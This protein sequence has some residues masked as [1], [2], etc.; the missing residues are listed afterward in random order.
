MDPASPDARLSNYRLE[1][2]L[3]Q[4]GM[5]AVYLARDLALDRPVAIKFISP[6]RA[7][8]PIARQ[9]L[10]REARAAASLDHPNICVIHEVIDEP[11]GRAGSV[12]QYVEGETLASKLRNGPLDVRLALSIAAEMASALAVAHKRGIIHR[13]IKPQNIV[14]T[15]DGHAKLLDF[16]LALQNLPVTGED[17]TTAAAL[18]TPGALAGTPAYMS[19]EQAQG[20]PLDGRSDL[21]SLGCVL[22]ECLTGRRPFQGSTPYETAHHVL[23]A[24]PPAPS[25]VRSELSA[26]H[27][28][29]CL[30]LLAKHRDDRFQS[31]DELLGAVRL[32]TSGSHWSRAVDSGSPASGAERPGLLRMAA[33]SRG[34]LAAL[35]VLVAVAFV[36]VAWAAWRARPVEGPPATET[37]VGVLPFVNATGDRSIDSLA[38]GLT[39]AIA[40]RLASIPSLRVLPLEETREA[41]QEQEDRAVLATR[42]TSARA[43]PVAIAKNLGAAFVIDGSVVFAGGEPEVLATLVEVDG[44]RHPAGQ[45]RGSGQVFELHR[46]VTQALVAVLAQQGVIPKG[47]SVA[48]PPTTDVEAFAE[49]SQGR[50]FLERPDVPGN[51]NHAVRL[52]QSAIVRDP[53]FALAHAGLAEAY[54]AQWRET[55]DESWTLKAVAAN[56]DALKIDPDQPEVRM[57]LAVTYAAQGRHDDAITEVRQVLDRQPDNDG[58]HR[59]L[60]DVHAARTEWAEAESEARR[61]IA[62]RPA[63]WRNHHQLGLVF[64]DAGRYQEAAAAFGRVVQLQPD[65]ARGYQTLGTALQA[66]GRNDEALEQYERAITIRP[67]G[68]TYSNIGTLYFWRGNYPAA[69]KAYESAVAMLPND[70]ALRANLG[71]AYAKVGEGARATQSYRQAVADVEKLL[72]VRPADAQQLAALALYRAKLGEH[73]SARELIDRAIGISPND[74]QVL[75][76]SALVH[77]IAGDSASACRAV[78]SA[79]ANG[80]SVEEIRHA[81]ELR[82]IR[83]CAAYDQLIQG[84]QASR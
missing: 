25:S 43:D 72:R 34:R 77:A 79:V 64:F 32:S 23:S 52:F 38:V 45:H 8:D 39:G 26:H 47:E 82:T 30:R 65:S 3:G 41:A 59:I 22:Y 44:T 4:G 14:L 50:V 80:A 36:A 40:K 74:G 58:A 16:G 35:I 76:A 67:S 46:V 21:F 1:R 2:L 75:Y 5:G 48:A 12:M 9:R 20:L 83:S 78:T 51:L 55:G 57:S 42:E 71:D 29:L 69:I 56:L 60:S 66:A 13:D 15:A 54:W 68:R 33:A 73:R 37:V 7:A 63:Y 31:A 61:A 49:Y 27:D 6:D 24:D 17:D 62:S 84:G 28:E 10:L 19:P 81:G 53:R 11:G 70:P 18:T